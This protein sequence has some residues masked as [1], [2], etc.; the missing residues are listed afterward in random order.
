MYKR[1][2]HCGIEKR[3]LSTP[4][5]IRMFGFKGCLFHKMFTIYALRYNNNCI[6]LNM[7]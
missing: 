2:Y 6:N 4:N 1:D 3:G 5:L 7:N